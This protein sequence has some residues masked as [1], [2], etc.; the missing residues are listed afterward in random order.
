MN[1]NMNEERAHAHHKFLQKTSIGQ[2]CLNLNL[3]TLLSYKSS[4]QGWMVCGISFLTREMVLEKWQYSENYII[5]LMLCSSR[6][7][8][9]VLKSFA[10][11]KS[12]SKTII[13]TL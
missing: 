11:D 12:V 6:Q 5:V 9:C 7:D 3:E 10:A 4:L 2:Q 1:P 13:P 8:P